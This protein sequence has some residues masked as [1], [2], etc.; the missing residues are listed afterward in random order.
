[1]PEIPNQKGS[2]I[3]F[4]LYADKNK[5]TVRA[6]E[7]V[8][9]GSVNIY[10]VRFEFS[11]D[12]EGLE[13]AA[14]FKSGAESRS[15]PLDSGGECV[16]PWEVLAAHGQPLTAGVFGTRDGDTVLP[17]VWAGLGIVLEGVAAGADAQPPTPDLWRQ[18]L[19]GKGDRLDYTPGGELGL[20]GGGKL[21]SAVPVAGGGGEGSLP[22]HRLLSHRDAE[23]QHPI[24]AIDGLEG[25]LSRIPEPVEAL[26]NFDL[27]VLLK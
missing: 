5:L 22:D 13:R 1:M 24:T 2:D 14:V 20:Y 10:T 7:P 26:T 12:W 11:S 6:R 17:T 8:T 21:L 25:E 15:V 4:V 16:I 23:K 27:E 19:A 18:E 3:I 9:S